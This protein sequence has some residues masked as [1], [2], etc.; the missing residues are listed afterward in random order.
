MRCPPPFTLLDPSTTYHLTLC[1]QDHQLNPPRPNW[2]APT[3]F[4]T[5]PAGGR[6]G[7]LFN[8]GRRQGL[9]HGPGRQQQDSSSQPARFPTWSPDGTKIASRARLDGQNG[10]ILMNADGSNKVNF[11]ISGRFLRRDRARRTA[12]RSPTPSTT[13]ARAQRI[14]VMNADGTQQEAA[15]QRRQRSEVLGDLETGRRADRLHQ[16]HVSAIPTA[17]QAD[18]RDERR[19]QQPAQH[20]QRPLGDRLRISLVADAPRSSSS[21][22]ATSGR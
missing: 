18:L 21:T 3:D 9:D 20:Q 22:T 4:Q 17:P 14:W 8:G 5:P 10:I 1:A 13:P 15:R 19:R 2:T 7:I 16:T 12:P 6:S 11:A